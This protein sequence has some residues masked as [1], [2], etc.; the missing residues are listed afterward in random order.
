MKNA[1]REAASIRSRAL[2][3]RKRMLFLDFDGTLSPIVTHPARARLPRSVREALLLCR[4]RFCVV[5]VSG[6]SLADIEKRVGIPGIVYAGNHG[7][8]WMEKGMRRAMPLS[9]AAAR[10]VA[11]AAESF[12]ALKRR[13][14]GAVIEHKGYSV[15]LNYRAV[16]QSK[17]GALARAA[18][19]ALADTSA[20]LRIRRDAQTIECVPATLWHKGAFV[21]TFA[22]GAFSIYIGDGKTDEDA[23]RALSDVTIRVGRSRASAARYFVPRQRDVAVLLRMLCAESGHGSGTIG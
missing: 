3:T 20:Y 8:E 9:A 18:L 6:R 4:K 17:R 13:Y 22:R 15:T 10:A 2:R 11:R 19:A 16:A 1:L 23:F 14:R 5:I 7:Y 21:R 12:L